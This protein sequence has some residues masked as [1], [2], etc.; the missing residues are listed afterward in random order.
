MVN[1]ELFTPASF[2]KLFGVTVQTILNWVESGKLKPYQRIGKKM[3]FSAN[4]FV[5]LQV[6]EQRKKGSQS[7]L[8]IIVDD[9]AD[10]IDNEISKF[11]GSVKQS[12][13]DAL[14]IDDILQYYTGIVNQEPSDLGPQ[15][16]SL[17]RHKVVELFCK[18]VHDS[19]L[20]FVMDIFNNVKGS[21]DFSL[22][23]F[24]KVFFGD[25]VDTSE[26]EKLELSDMKYTVNGMKNYIDIMYKNF[27]LKYGLL[28]LE[29][30]T[31]KNAYNHDVSS[32]DYDNLQV[33]RK[34]TLAKKVYKDILGN[35]EKY[36]KRNLI[37]EIC[38][39][40]Y[41]SVRIGEGSLSSDES[42]KI[43]NQIVRKDYEYVYCNNFD[44][45]P[46]TLRSLLT[47]MRDSDVIKFLND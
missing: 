32:V 30:F 28:N 4:Q 39:K 21:E 20:S 11:V 37:D 8:G 10:V 22:S 41:Y 44:N 13:P 26:Y 2:A 35:V 23:F 7:Y 1:N 17:F 27:V 16:E 6:E 29:S 25:D 47:A 38:Q 43:I 45:L 19:V 31:L 14:N 9:D 5:T 12:L 15:G 42:E 34:E 18:D 33:N 46:D 40:G 36:T 24:L 3:F